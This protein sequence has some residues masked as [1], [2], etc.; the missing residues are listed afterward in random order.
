MKPRTVTVRHGQSVNVRTTGT[1]SSDGP[2]SDGPVTDVPV[3]DGPVTDG[4]VTHG[5]VNAPVC[6]CK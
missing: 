1:D 3:P 4:P 2:V 6:I 5:P